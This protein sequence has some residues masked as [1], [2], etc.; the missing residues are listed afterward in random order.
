MTYHDLLE[1]LLDQPEAVRLEQLKQL[2]EAQ[3]EEFAT[4]WRLWARKDQLPPTSDWR[5]W[6]ILAE[7]DAT[8][9]AAQAELKATAFEGLIAGRET[10]PTDSHTFACPEDEAALLAAVERALAAMA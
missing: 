10:L 6:L 1:W 7:G 9:I 2:S 8:A 3:R 4:H 5:V